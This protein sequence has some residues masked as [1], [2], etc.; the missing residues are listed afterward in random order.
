[1]TAPSNAGPITVLSCRRSGRALVERDSHTD[2]ITV[3][4]DL[5]EQPGRPGSLAPVNRY[6]VTCAACGTATEYDG[7]WPASKMGGSAAGIGGRA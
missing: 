2:A 6:T 7:P 3:H 4:G 1:V 5:A